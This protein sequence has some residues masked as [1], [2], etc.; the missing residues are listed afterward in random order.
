RNASEIVSGYTEAM[1][2]PQPTNKADILRFWG[3]AI[4]VCAL[5]G[6]VVYK[7]HRFFGLLPLFGFAFIVFVAFKHGYVRHDGHEVAATNLLALAALLW[8]PVAWQIVWKQRRWL[9]PAVLL[10]LIFATAL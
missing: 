1:M 2:W 10:P 8:L 5:V 6:Y 4:A 3:V 9:T 7:Q